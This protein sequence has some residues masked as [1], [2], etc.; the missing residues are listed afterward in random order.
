MD[1][2]TSSQIKQ[3]AN[4]VQNDIWYVSIWEQV[5]TPWEMLQSNDWTSK[6]I[7]KTKMK[8]LIS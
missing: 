5:G 3:R 2:K 1:F 7:Q 8:H 4:S 6:N